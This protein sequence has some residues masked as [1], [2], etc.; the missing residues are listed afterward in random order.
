MKNRLKD[1]FYIW[2]ELAQFFVKISRFVE[3]YKFVNLRFVDW[4]N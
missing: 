2:F 1:D 4:R 3:S